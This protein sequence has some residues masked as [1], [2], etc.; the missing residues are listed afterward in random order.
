MEKNLKHNLYNLMEVFF[1][2]FFFLYYFG[3]NIVINIYIFIIYNSK[4]VISHD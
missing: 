3:N 2:L 4:I 1:F